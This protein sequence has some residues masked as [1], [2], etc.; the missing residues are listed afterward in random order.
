MS[1]FK[2]RLKT[3]RIELEEKLNKLNE[4]NLSERVNEVG[5]DQ[6]SLLLIQA[7]AMFTYLECLKARL[8][9]L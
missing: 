3:E 9:R 7:G 1:D 8:E 4:F 6:K 5:A 2:Q